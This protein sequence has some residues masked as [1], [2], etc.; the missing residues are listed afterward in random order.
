MADEPTPTEIPAEGGRP[1]GLPEKFQSVEALAAAYE[2]SQ[3]E[4][5]RAQTQSQQQQ[6]QFAAALENLQQQA[7][8]Q[9]P[10]QPAYDPTV[11]AFTQAW[12][13]GDAQGM[14]NAMAQNSTAQT[15]DAVGRLMDEKFAQLTPAVQAATVAQREHDLRLAEGLAEREL[16]SERYRELLPRIREIASDNGNLLPQASSVEGYAAS[17]LQI[18]KLAE[19]DTIVR[20]NEELQAE[21]DE[22][23]AAQTLTGGYSRST[24]NPDWAKAE[25][26][27]IKGTQTGSFEEMMQR[28]RGGA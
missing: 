4:M 21:R 13:Q 23:L 24:V 15:V 28:Q 22:K 20:Q 7:P 9:Y 12:E 25:F 19:Y 6:E 3:R 27:R 1:D 5:S 14:M 8:P 11:S 26:E 16:G 18:A 10:Q 17:I 2:E